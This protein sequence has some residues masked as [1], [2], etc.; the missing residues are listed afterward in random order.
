MQS[1]LR[2]WK[3]QKDSIDLE[4]EPLYL[5]MACFLW[6][7]LS[8]NLK[9]FESKTWKSFCKCILLVSISDGKLSNAWSPSFPVER[10]WLFKS[11]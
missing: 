1:D 11:C 4:T 6:N 8:L 9:I 5:K 7:L 2:A 10:E 3:A